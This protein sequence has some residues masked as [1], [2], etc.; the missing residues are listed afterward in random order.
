MA[1]NAVGDAATCDSMAKLV[2]KVSSIQ[3]D[4]PSVQQMNTIFMIFFI[5]VNFK[6][7]Y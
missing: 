6:N 1:A 7:D 3:L 2:G 4:S 5:V